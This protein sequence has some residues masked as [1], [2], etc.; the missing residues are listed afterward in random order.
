LDQNYSGTIT[1]QPPVAVAKPNA[2]YQLKD[3][4]TVTMLL[5]AQRN[6]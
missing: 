4:D 5:R 1:T 6:F 2:I 3:Q